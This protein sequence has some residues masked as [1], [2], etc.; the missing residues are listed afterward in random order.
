MKALIFIIMLLPS[1]AIA[2]RYPPNGITVYQSFA[3]LPSVAYNGQQGVTADTD[4]IYIYSLP[5]LTWVQVTSAGAVVSITAFGSSPNSAG[6]SVAA[7]A[8]TLQPADATHP[9]GVSTGSQSFGGTKTFANVIDSGL[10]ASTALIANG[11]KQIASSSTTDIELGYVHG[12]TSAIQTQ[13]DSK[14]P[15]LTAGN[16]TDAGTDG[17]VVTGGTGAVIGSG[18]SLA[19]H[20]ADSGHNG[21]LSSA[22]W[23]TFNGKQASGS[24]ITALTGDVAASGPG[25]AVATLAST[26][27]GAKTFSTSLTSPIFSTSSSN[28]AVSGVLRLAN[29]ESIAWRNSVNASDKTITVDSSNLMQIVSNGIVLSGSIGVQAQQF[30]STNTGFSG[31]SA[32]YGSGLSLHNTEPVA[33]QNA[34]NTSAFTLS[35]DASN[36][37]QSTAPF[38]SS[39]IVKGSQL[40]SIVSTGT[41]PLIVASTTR[42][43]N[44]NV[45][46]AG[47]AD[48]VTTNANLTGDV[49]SVGNATTIANNAVTNAKSAQMAANTIKGN[50]TGST[51]NAVDL[52]VAQLASLLFVATTHQTFT[53]GTAQTY[54]L[55]TSPRSPLYIKIRMVGGGGGGG[56]SG[57]GSFGTPTAGGNTT[58]SGGSLSAVGGGIGGQSGTCAGGTASGGNIANGTGSA[59]QGPSYL[60]STGA[61]QPETAG[62]MGGG[63]LLGPGGGGGAYGTAGSAGGGWGAGGGGGGGALVSGLYAG[64]GGCGAGYVEHQINSPAATYTYTVGAAG[65]A[66][67][68]GTGGFASGPGTGG[69]IIIDEFYQ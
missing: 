53:S 65:G 44:L 3:T 1:I 22:D 41:A 21:Y 12:V 15:T 55:P 49:T 37:L 9:G 59:G 2:Q 56:A 68:A 16:L 42:V 66:A 36:I 40:Q 69:I 17:I 43:S 64:G 34:A 52:T 10:T 24:Y 8:L 51:A 20:V 26:I 63:S 47:T 4:N 58:F 46:T 39:G 45:A 6:G 29:G 28:P 30:V 23:S 62:G 19:Q 5:T 33:W 31:N 57:T 60:N 50:N 61:T 11:S 7:N 48:T 32:F 18:A 13:L 38:T 14:Q 25:S 67:T 27:S 35:L 54:T